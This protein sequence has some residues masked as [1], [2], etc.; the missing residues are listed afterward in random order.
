[1][2]TTR[3][4]GAL[5]AAG[6]LVLALAGTASAVVD[7]AT[8]TGHEAF[9]SDANQESYWGEDCSKINTGEGGLGESQQ[10]F[11]LGASYGL[12]VVK[13]G[14]GDYA[15]TLF[16][17]A[18]AGEVVWADTDGN[19]AFDGTEPAISHIIFCDEQETTTTTTEET[20]TTTT[21]TQETSGETDVP[22]EPPTTTFGG[23]VS[24]PSDGSWLLVLALGIFLAS[25]VIL[26]PAG[27]KSRR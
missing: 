16:E 22:T 8:V 24:G 13:S 1:M 11:E 10:T 14:A 27:A 19:S 18:S 23:G 4:L 9:S 2:S 26:T 3:K 25:V 7:Y 5:A 12:V 15:N 20:T 21:F 6:A 17:D